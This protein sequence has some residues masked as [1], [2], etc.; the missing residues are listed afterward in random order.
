MYEAMLI[1]NHVAKV[2]IKAG[3]ALAFV[4]G[5]NILE[6]ECQLAAPT[7]DGLKNQLIGISAKDVKAGETVTSLPIFVGHIVQVRAGG[8]FSAGTPLGV[9]ANGNFVEAGSG[10]AAAPIIAKQAA[11][12]AGDMV[13]AEIVHT[14]G[15]L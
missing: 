11:T 9:D 7:V 4:V 13:L 3:Q 10:T 6:P 1:Q 12:A 14:L 2:D 8:A 15:I 5:D